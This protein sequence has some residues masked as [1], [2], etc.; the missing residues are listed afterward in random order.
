[1]EGVLLFSEVVMF[2]RIFKCLPCGL[3]LLMWIYRSNALRGN[4]EKSAIKN[5]ST[6][7]QV[8]VYRFPRRA[9]EPDL[10]YHINIDT[11]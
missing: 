2:A 11:V 7:K 5:P 6:F 9:W 4:V 1:M 8:I 10:R 3:N